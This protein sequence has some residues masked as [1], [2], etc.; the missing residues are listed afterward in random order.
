MPSPDKAFLVKLLV[1]PYCAVRDVNCSLDFFFS[2]GFVPG[3][4]YKP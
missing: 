3:G 4:G 2:H 1:K